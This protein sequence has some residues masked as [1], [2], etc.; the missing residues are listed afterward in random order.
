[1]GARELT[2]LQIASFDNEV[3]GAGAAGFDLAGVAV[4]A[5]DDDGSGMEGVLDVVAGAVAG[6]GEWGKG[7]R[8]VGHCGVEGEQC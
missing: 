3:E 6:P 4:A 8:G 1:M 7:G 2:E 5:V